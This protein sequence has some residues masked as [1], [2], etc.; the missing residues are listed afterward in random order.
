MIKNCPVTV[1]HI[2][3]AEDVFVPDVLHLKGKTTRSSPKPVKSDEIM[4][5]IGLQE[6]TGCKPNW[7]QNQ[8]NQNKDHED[9]IGFPTVFAIFC[10]EG[11][12][13]PRIWTKLGGNSSYKPPGASYIAQ[14]P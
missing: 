1:E 4:M 13:L 11:E 5:L 10:F 12:R 2:G 9:F 14:G 3:G 7:N 6:W 8:D